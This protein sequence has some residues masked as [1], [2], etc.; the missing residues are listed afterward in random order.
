MK[1]FKK[2]QADTAPEVQ[3][4]ASEAITAHGRT[5]GKGR[6]TPKRRE[7]QA[8]RLQPVVPSDRKAAKRAA[9]AKQDEAW[10]RQRQAMLTGDE[11]YLPARDKG[12]IKRYI[13]DYV[14]ARFSVG[15]LFL[16]AA[17]VLLLV[18]LGLSFAQ[19]SA[20]TTMVS[21][22]VMALIYCLFLIAIIDSIVCWWLVRRRLY[23]KFGA[24]T[25]RDSG[26]IGF[27]VFSRC[28]N[29][30]RWRQPAPQVARRE[31]PS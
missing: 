4:V 13:R 2:A 24:Q 22:Y 6:P 11:R 14:D 8:R 28:F 15:E 21:F 25:V 16:P 18:S 30:R 31:Y 26:M 10:Q 1:P 9:R 7:A 23:A 20:S 29:L 19:R 5:A 12:P 3:T 27:Y 17:L